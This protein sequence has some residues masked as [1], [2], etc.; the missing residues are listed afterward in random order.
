MVPSTF[1]AGAHED[2]TTSFDLIHTKATGATH[3]DVRNVVVNLPAGFTANNTA[4]QTRSQTQLLAQGEPAGIGARCPPGSQI[5]TI[6]LDLNTQGEPVPSTFP[7][8]N[9]EATSF[10]VAAELGFKTAAL[11]S[12]NS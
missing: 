9:M 1:A 3:N 7:L 6:T 4:V 8:Y 2:L 12:R 11:S 5:G 10:G